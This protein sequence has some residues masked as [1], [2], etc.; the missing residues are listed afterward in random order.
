VLR[1][2][3]ALAITLVCDTAQMESLR[4]PAVLPAPGQDRLTLCRASIVTRPIR[5]AYK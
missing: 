3:S 2:W 1:Q 4:Q 5:L